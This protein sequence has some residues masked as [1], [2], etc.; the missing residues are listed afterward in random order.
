MYAIRSY[1]EHQDGEVSDPDP[2][3][4]EDVRDEYG[5]VEP[6]PE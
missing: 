5:L 6:V 3:L 2:D 1:Y 4:Q